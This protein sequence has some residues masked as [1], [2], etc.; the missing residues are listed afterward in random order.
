MDYC[1]IDL[2]SVSS[3]VCVTGRK[4]TAGEAATDR[5]TFEQRLER[6]NR[7]AEV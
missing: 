6:G 2:A 1:G 4:L 5:T 7:Y 3:Y